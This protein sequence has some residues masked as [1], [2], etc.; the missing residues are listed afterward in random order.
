MLSIRDDGFA[1]MILHTNEQLL[2]I[3]KMV[4]FPLIQRVSRRWAACFGAC[5]GNPGFNGGLRE[6]MLLN[7]FVDHDEVGDIMGH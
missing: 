2:G 1:E 4:N 3:A 6:V 5:V 7:R